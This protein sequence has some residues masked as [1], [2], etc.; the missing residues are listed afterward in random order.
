MSSLA[1]A[2]RSHQTLKL[3]AI[4]SL[5]GAFSGLFGVGGGT[6]IV[7]LL[8]FWF[9]YGERL[10]TGT[11]LAAIVLIGLLGALAQGG[12]Y[13]NVHVL[14]GLLLAIPAIGGVVLGTAIQQRIPQRAVSYLFAGLL[15]AIAIEL[16]LK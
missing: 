14:T 11:S 13:G 15:V 9:A 10:A 4:G 7:P 2:Q 8:I 5:A 6:V 12:I 16:I 3:A 1:G